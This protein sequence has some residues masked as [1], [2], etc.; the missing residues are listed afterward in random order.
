MLTLQDI[1]LNYFHYNF[2]QVK[3]N[4][5][6]TLLFSHL[7]PYMVAN[8]DE[9]TRIL[10]AQQPV[11]DCLTEI[12][13]SLSSE[14]PH[15]ASFLSLLH[16]V[17]SNPH[18]PILTPCPQ[19][20]ISVRTPIPG[21]IP[22]SFDEPLTSTNVISTITGPLV[23][24]HFDTSVVITWHSPHNPEVHQSNLDLRSL[25]VVTYILFH[26]LEE[27]P[28]FNGT[29]PLK[30][31]D[32][33]NLSHDL[34]RLINIDKSVFQLLPHIHIT[35][36]LTTNS[37]QVCFQSLITSTNDIACMF[38]TLVD[39]SLPT[40][41][42]DLIPICSNRTTKLKHHLNLT[43]ESKD[44][45]IPVFFNCYELTMDIT[46]SHAALQRIS[47]DHSFEFHAFNPHLTGINQFLRKAPTHIYLA[48]L[49]YTL[50]GFRIPCMSTSD[51][52]LPP[53]PQW[54]I[55]YYLPQY[56]LSSSPDES[57]SLSII[58]ITVHTTDHDSP[59]AV[60]P[61]QA[62]HSRHVDAIILHAFHLQPQLQTL[63]PHSYYDVCHR[64]QSAYTTQ[65]E[66][67]FVRPHDH[68]LHHEVYWPFDFR[69]N[70]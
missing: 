70:A 50:T 18:P 32:L 57:P 35:P 44:P 58:I 31:K 36:G 59:S 38:R 4:R 16:S 8:P 12:S 10:H 22:A 19:D 26:H 43:A 2:E 62:I 14:S 48:I 20:L 28:K 55:I 56:G 61:L 30:N 6:R 17:S 65:F 3:S 53:P 54:L 27:T 45:E 34:F 68:Y 40:W 46:P 42:R 66:Y 67:K 24:H 13:I 1:L 23:L 11:L 69:Y 64:I 15:R 5:R 25:I 29:P 21:L 60:T 47:L 52:C 49:Q 9:T 33:E 51:N 39:M 63:I 41:Y 7:Q 37:E